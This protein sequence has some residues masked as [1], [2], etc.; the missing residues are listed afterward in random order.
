MV[1][2]ILVAV[3]GSAAASRGARFAGGLAQQTGA[4]LTVLVAVRP[5]SSFLVPGTDAVSITASH[6]DAEHLAAAQADID[7]L[8]TELGHGRAVPSVLVG[9]DAADAILT[10]AA[11]GGV[12]LVVVGARGIGAVQR[13][14][15]GSVSERVVRECTAPV[16]VVR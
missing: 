1:Q 10:E 11:R 6:P 4:R 16:V 13:A 14:L 2:H 3:D 7:R 8:V 15:L 5:P 12:D 9:P